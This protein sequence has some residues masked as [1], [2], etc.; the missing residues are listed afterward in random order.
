MIREIVIYG[1]PVLRRK[2][3]QIDKI[4]EEIRTLAQDMIETKPTP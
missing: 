3:K 4:T 2:G 1:D